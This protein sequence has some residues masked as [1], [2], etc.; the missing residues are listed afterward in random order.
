MTTLS[1][2]LAIALQHHQA[3]RLPEAEEIYRQVLQ[4]QPNQVDALQL[5]GVIVYQS[6]KLEEAIAYYRQALALNPALSQV[7]GN[8][9]IALNKQGLLEEATQ[10]YQK[11][12]SLNPT[13]AQFHYNLG[14]ALREL[15]RLESATLHFKQATALQ[16]DF[17]EAYDNLGDVLEQQGQYEEALVCYDKAI[18]LKPNFALA[19]FHRART[20]LRRGDFSRGFAEYEWRWAEDIIGIRPPFEAPLWDGSDLKGKTILLYGEQGYGDRIQFIRYAPL[21]RERG[22]RVIDVCLAP[23]TGILATVPGI[24]QV[25]DLDAEVPEF[26][27]HAPLMSLPYLL[28]TTPETI[29]AQIPYL[30]APKSYNIKLKS[31]PKTRLKVGIVWAGNV[32][33]RNFRIRTCGLQSF[34]PLLETPGVA[35]YSLQVGSRSQELAAL[36]ASIQVQDL[37]GQLRDFT[38]TATVIAQLDLVITIDT[39]VAHLAGALGK[40]V[41]VLLPF[42]ADWRWML[43]REDSPWYPTMRLFRQESLGDWSGVMARVAEALALAL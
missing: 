25:V 37:S 18:E 1:E 35:F 5:L 6:G 32:I 8:L 31:P 30:R 12:I 39:S 7:H 22:G 20:L 13:S 3:G 41:W 17:V 4:Q 24:D 11:A 16:K 40:P 33:S 26:D 42:V 19:H 34:F 2:S 10:H 43:R 9:G 23:L 27:F 14:I 28:G 15:D 29:P 21:V 36:P 38:D